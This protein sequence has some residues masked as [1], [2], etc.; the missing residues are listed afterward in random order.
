[1]FL[2]VCLR[3]AIRSAPDGPQSSH[4]R[5]GKGMSWIIT[6]ELRRKWT[7]WKLVKMVTVYSNWDGD[8][9]MND[10]SSAEA[11]FF[12]QLFFSRGSKDQIPSAADLSR[13]FMTGVWSSFKN[14]GRKVALTLIRAPFPLKPLLNLLVIMK[15]SSISPSHSLGSSLPNL[16]GEK[17]MH[18]YVELL[19]DYR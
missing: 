13:A 10:A 6:E 18:E 7:Q 16:K 2:C 5:K 15:F 4:K 17:F 12:H 11:R 8:G 9:P 3:S 1:M 19:I 14:L